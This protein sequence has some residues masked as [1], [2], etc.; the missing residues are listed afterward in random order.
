MS[1]NISYLKSNYPIHSPIGIHER[2]K[3]ISLSP[4]NGRPQRKSIIP[5]TIKNEIL[6]STESKRQRENDA[7]YIDYIAPR[8]SLYQQKTNKKPIYQNTSPLK[9][10]STSYQNTLHNNYPSVA[11]GKAQIIKEQNLYL[12]Q[13]I[14]HLND[15]L[16]EKSK[17][18][19]NL[20]KK[21]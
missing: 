1:K 10:I 16:T 2:E 6:P 21:L 13:E 12:T 4:H 19:L 15:L 11:S 14:T 20:E 3:N 8:V 17:V 18:I 7:D 9:P 5:S